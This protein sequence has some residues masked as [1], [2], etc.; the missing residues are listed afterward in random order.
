[1]HESSLPFLP[2]NIK[3]SLTPTM[4]WM[5]RALLQC[6]AAEREVASRDR[7][8]QKALS[9]FRL[10]LVMCY[11]VVRRGERSTRSPQQRR[12][13][14]LCGDVTAL[15]IVTRCRQLSNLRRPRLPVRCPRPSFMWIALRH[16]PRRQF[17]LLPVLDRAVLVDDRAE[18]HARLV[19]QPH[20]RFC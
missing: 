10:L 8:F 12:Q 4:Q 13:G 16:L 6:H 2:G 7:G 5:K 17:G 18:R 15:G 9:L 11:F 1:M 14:S 20:R 19:Q 3:S